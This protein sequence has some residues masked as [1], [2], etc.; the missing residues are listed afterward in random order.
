MTKHEDY[1]DHEDGVVLK[2]KKT[3]DRVRNQF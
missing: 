2:E 1:D 3:H